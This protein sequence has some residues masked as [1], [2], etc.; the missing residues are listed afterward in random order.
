MPPCIGGSSVHHMEK[1]S[2][3]TTT[4]YCLCTITMLIIHTLVADKL[5]RQ[6]LEEVY[7]GA[8]D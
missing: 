1:I 8:R 5:K 2:G 3:L 4:N 6:W 7:F